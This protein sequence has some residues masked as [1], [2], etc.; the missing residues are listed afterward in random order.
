M[1][2]N[3]WIT[4]KLLANQTKSFTI[5]SPAR[6]NKRLPARDNTLLFRIVL[7][8]SVIIALYGLVGK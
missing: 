1:N 4:H 2:K 6:S 8:S 7:A 5:I 3:Q